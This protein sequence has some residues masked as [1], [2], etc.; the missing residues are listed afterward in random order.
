MARV[1][2]SRLSLDGADDPGRRDRHRVDVLA[3]PPRER[4]AQPPALG[5]QRCERALDV[6]FGAGSDAAATSERKP[7]PRRQPEPSG[8]DDQTTG[9]ERPAEARGLETEQPECER[10]DRGLAGA[11]QAA[12]LLPPGMVQ[13]R[14]CSQNPR[15]DAIAPWFHRPWTGL[16]V[17]SG[18]R[19]HTWSMWRSA[20]AQP[21]TRR[22]TTRARRA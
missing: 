12:V 2:A 20:L 3:A 15:L 13:V 19:S 1:V 21:G 16:A 5:L 11:G 18:S 8:D 4:M 17:I 14:R 10:A 22:L 9:D 6:L 7:T